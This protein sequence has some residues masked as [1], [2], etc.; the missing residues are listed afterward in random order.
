MNFNSAENKT[1]TSDSKLQP[2]F[3]K[4]PLVGFQV[5]SK[6]YNYNYLKRPLKYFSSFSHIYVWIRTFFVYIPTNG[7]LNIHIEASMRIHLSS[8]RH[9]RDLQKCKILPFQAFLVPRTW[10][11]IQFSK[12]RNQ[13]SLKKW[14][15]LGLGQ[16]I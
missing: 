4:L 15:V 11:Q 7:R 1:L 14:I 8:I 13:G 10:F 12:K 3:K 2:A 5:V 9:S 6:K 16:E